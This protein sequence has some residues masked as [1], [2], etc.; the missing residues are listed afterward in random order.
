M[1]QNIQLLMSGN[2]NAAGVE[3]RQQIA[4]Q[5]AP[6]ADNAPRLIE[7]VASFFERAEQL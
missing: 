7:L 1:A 2:T 6:L 5:L 3:L 4:K